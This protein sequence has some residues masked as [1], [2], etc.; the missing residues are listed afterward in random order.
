MSQEGKLSNTKCN[1]YM[2]Q[3]SA[4]TTG[5]YSIAQTPVPPIKINDNEGNIVSI[6]P[7]PSR[8]SHKSLGY[9]QSTTNQPK[10]QERWIR[11]KLHQMTAITR[12][13]ALNYKETQIYFKTIYHPR[14]QYVSHLSSLPPTMGEKITNQGIYHILPQ[15]GYCSS[16]PDGISL[17][18]K[19]YGGLGLTNVQIEEGARNLIIFKTGLE[20]QSPISN[21]IQITTKWWWLLLGTENSPFQFM[22]SEITY[23]KTNWFAQIHCFIHNFDII[24]NMRFKNY[25]KLRQNDAYIMELVLQQGYTQKIVGNINQCCLFLHVLTLSD[26]VDVTGKF[27]TSTNYVHQEAATMN[28]QQITT[29]QV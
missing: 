8:T 3:M 20:Y 6:S 28:T 18:H 17:G 9:Q 22:P 26:I 12:S 14:V 10:I 25:P 21:M 7:V 5:Q 27:I 15:M 4:A 11:T 24:I 1:Y 2:H 29:F 19:K 16:T 23:V 13:A